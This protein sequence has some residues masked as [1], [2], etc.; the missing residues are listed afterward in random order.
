MCW[1]VWVVL[2][3]ALALGEASLATAPGT[4]HTLGETP[5]TVREEV[6]A[7][8]IGATP[9][10][11]ITSDKWVLNVAENGYNLQLLKYLKHLFMGEIILLMKK[12]SLSLTR[13]LRLLLRRGLLLLLNI[14][15]WRSPQDTSRALKRNRESGVLLLISNI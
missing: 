3:L 11:N 14:A 9:R 12:P 7:L 6:E 15:P 4:S 1:Q 13:R 8:E 10:H 5:G 2:N